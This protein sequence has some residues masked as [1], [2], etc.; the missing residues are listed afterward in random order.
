MSNISELAAKSFSLEELANRLRDHNEPAVR[1][2]AE[3]VITAIDRREI[4]ESE[5]SDAF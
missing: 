4:L 1:I 2:L 5:D 3:K